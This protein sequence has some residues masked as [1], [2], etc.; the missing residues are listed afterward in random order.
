MMSEQTVTISADTFNK[1]LAV[2]QAAKEFTSNYFNP[3]IDGT[4]KYDRAMDLKDALNRFENC[5]FRQAGG[6]D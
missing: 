3:M 6:H 4:E 2:K 1:L 5:V